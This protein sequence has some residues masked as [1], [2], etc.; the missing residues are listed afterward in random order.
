MSDSENV[1]STSADGRYRVIL[2]H[3]SDG[4][5]PETD[6]GP[7]VYRHGFTDRYATLMG[8]PDIDGY[9]D[10]VR[11]FGRDDD[12]VARY[13]RIFRDVVSIDYGDTRDAR[14]VAVVTGAMARD[15]GHDENTSPETLSK[16]AHVAE[17]V[18]WA[19][20]E[21]YAWEI[22]ERVNWTTDADYPDRATWETVDSCGG[23]YGTE[24][25]EESA[26][27]EFADR[28]HA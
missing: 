14:Y 13:L 26:R 6:F 28:G 27:E 12:A 22:Q 19:E 10:A 24:Y 2:T 16:L 20:G 4:G 9:A 5:A 3:D 8:G 7:A 15:W 23:Y 17:W 18:A 21:V 1:V 25:A 11:H